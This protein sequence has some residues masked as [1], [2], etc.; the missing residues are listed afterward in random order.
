MTPAV[1]LRNRAARVGA[2]TVPRA[3]RWR[4]GRAAEARHVA[5]A[6]P[7]ARAMRRVWQQ[8]PD[9]LDIAAFHVES[10]MNLRPWGYWM[11]D[12]RPYDGTAEIVELTERILQRHASHPGAL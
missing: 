7:P 2:G 12:G 5:G 6:Y 1:S 3:S 10:V 11:R 8:F 9:D 4:V